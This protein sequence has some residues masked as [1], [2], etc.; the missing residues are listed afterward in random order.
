MVG[1]NLDFIPQ[2][3]IAFLLLWTNGDPELAG[4]RLVN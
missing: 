3:R 4:W 1:K 2:R